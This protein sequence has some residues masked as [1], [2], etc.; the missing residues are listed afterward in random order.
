MKIPSSKSGRKRAR[1]PPLS[2]LTKG[3]AVN[4]TEN[5]PRLS[6][7]HKT[8]TRAMRGIASQAS[9]ETDNFPPSL[10]SESEE[11]LYEQ[12]ITLFMEFDLYDLQVQPLLV[13][14]LVLARLM[15]PPPRREKLLLPCSS[16][17][18]G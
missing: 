18:S 2:E 10:S 4:V 16:S 7:P 12:Q 8:I 6:P 5:R 9:F 13:V 15:P 1:L 14:G 11:G 17:R 3:W